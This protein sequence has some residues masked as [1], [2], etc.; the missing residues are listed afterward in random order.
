MEAPTVFDEDGVGESPSSSVVMSLELFQGRWI[1]QWTSLLANFSKVAFGIVVGL[2]TFGYE[3]ALEAVA[4]KL[5]LTQ[6]A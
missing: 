6:K 1:V 2:G 3:M 4:E 5:K